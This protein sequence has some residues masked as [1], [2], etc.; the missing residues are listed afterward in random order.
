MTTFM[1]DSWQRNYFFKG[2]KNGNFL[3]LWCFKI[4]ISWN[5]SIKKSFLS[6]ARITRFPWNTVYT[7]GKINTQFF[8]LI[9]FCQLSFFNR[10]KDACAK[11]ERKKL[12]SIVDKALYICFL[13]LRITNCAGFVFLILFAEK[14]E[15]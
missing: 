13:I 6:S 12:A 7:K 3:I 10:K 4:F 8:P 15:T 1:N 14:I 5:S 2:L 11:A 9:S